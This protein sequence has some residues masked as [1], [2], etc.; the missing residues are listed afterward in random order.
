MTPPAPPLAPAFL[1]RPIAHRGLHDA[2]RP[3][4]S[5]AAVRAAIAAGYG[6]EIDLQL[7]RDGKAMVFHDAT[8]DR[9]TA[10]TGPVHARPAADLCALPLNG[11]DEGMS[12]LDE[13]LD[14]VGGQVPLLI[15]IKDQQR[16]GP[17]IGPLEAEVARLLNGYPGAAEW[18]AVMSFNPRSMAEMARCAPGIPRGLTTFSW[19]EA[20]APGLSE[21]IRRRLRDIDDFDA[22]GASFISHD[23]AD[24]ARARVV[25]LRSRGVPVLCW[26]IRSADEE[27]AARV[28]ADNI[29]FEGYRPAA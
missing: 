2:V 13:M 23:V 16:A 9:M 20:E 14:L 1:R 10:A 22:V 19:P 15:E 5:R 12:T 11:G 29:T 4:N 28:L 27:R 7:S 3:E 25:S 18:V 24:L 6:I 26:T 8:L 17:G 21:D